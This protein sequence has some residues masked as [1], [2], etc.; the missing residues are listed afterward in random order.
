MAGRRA[1]AV[2]TSVGLAAAVV[3]LVVAA[4][5]P[6]PDR[7]LRGLLV[8]LSVTVILGV[9]GGGLQVIAAGRTTGRH[10]RPRVDGR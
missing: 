6:S 10:H 7:H 9:L 5:S 3:V 4:I 1:M 2:I 8:V